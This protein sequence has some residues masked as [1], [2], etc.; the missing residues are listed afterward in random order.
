MTFFEISPYNWSVKI[1]RFDNENEH[2]FQIEIRLRIEN[3][4]YMTIYRLLSVNFYRNDVAL[5]QQNEPKLD[6]MTGFSVFQKQ[7]ST[8][9][10]KLFA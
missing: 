7:L 1:A 6:E 5:K 3:L 4:T 8:A 9:A 10:K 2:V